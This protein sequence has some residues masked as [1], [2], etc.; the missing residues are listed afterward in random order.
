[1][2]HLLKE[3]KI[4]LIIFK[5]FVLSLIIFIFYNGLINYKGNKYLYIL[6]SIVSN[7]LLIF[8]F[9]KKTIFFD[10]FFSLL[11]WVGFWLKFTVII[12]FTGGMF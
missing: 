7:Y 6:F 3:N 1:M 2:S 10:T 8:S 5:L 4:I 11:L 12:S 9:R